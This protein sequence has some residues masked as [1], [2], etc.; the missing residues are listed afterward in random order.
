[1]LTLEQINQVRERPYQ[2]AK[3]Q[4]KKGKKVV[5]VVPSDVFPE[6]LFDAAGVVPVMLQPS[7]EPITVGLTY[8]PHYMCGITRSIVDQTA[9]A[10]LDFFDAFTYAHMCSQSY[11]M[12]EVM[13]YLKPNATLL[14]MQ[15]P[16]E[17][18]EGF[19]PICV[20]KMKK[21]QQDVEEWLGKKIAPET[22]KESIA[23]YNRYRALMRRL[24]DARRQKPG[25]IRNKELYNI[26][27][28]SQVMPKED[29]VGFLEKY[30]PEVEK[31]RA[32]RDSKVKVYLCGHHCSAVKADVLNLVEDVGAEVVW[33]DMFSGYRYVATDLSADRTPPE[34]I[35]QRWLN[36]AI[37]SPVRTEM[38]GEW[39]DYS[40]EAFEKSR[41]EGIIVL[42]ARQCGP[43]LLYH[44]FMKDVLDAANI[45]HLDLQIEHEVVSLEGI[46][47]RM[48][49]F[50]E[51]LRKRR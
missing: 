41:A 48:E 15:W 9:R 22:V 12:Y 28:A 26:V 10:E 43:H 49:A 31:R 34:A 40:V 17:T 30:V 42:M 4:K 44:S 13:R 39:A 2:W 29:I 21:F 6:E 3:E 32:P 25:V 1:M 37:P 51:M 14:F 45:P 20:D 5:G 18:G 11:R 19:F 35:A 33:D 7:M 38:K 27:T 23:L 50:V 24:F 47:T 8:F 16:L 46:R 36:V